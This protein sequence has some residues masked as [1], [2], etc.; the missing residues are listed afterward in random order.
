MPSFHCETCNKHYVRGCFETH[1]QTKKHQRKLKSI[2]RLRLKAEEYK[3]RSDIH[4]CDVCNINVTKK[5]KHSHNK[6]KCHLQKL[7]NSNKKRV[8]FNEEKNTVKEFIKVNHKKRNYREDENDSDIISDERD[9]KR[10]RVI[11][12]EEINSVN[13]KATVKKLKDYVRFKLESNS[14][15]SIDNNKECKT[16]LYKNQDPKY[17]TEALLSN[18]YFLIFKPEILDQIYKYNDIIKQLNIN[19]AKLTKLITRIIKEYAFNN[20]EK[21]IFN[22]FPDGDVFSLN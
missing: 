22:Q 16:F 15:S 17:F 8:L 12:Q 19:D 6:S 20:P 5:S 9:S 3:N 14:K 18:Y 21:D 13:N 11:S 1:E 4:Y 10:R 2:E 7:K